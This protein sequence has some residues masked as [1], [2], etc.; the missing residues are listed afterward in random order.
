MNEIQSCGR[1][2]RQEKRVKKYSLEGFSRRINRFITFFIALYPVL[3]IS[4]IFSEVW[5]R[6]QFQH[7]TTFF[8]SSGT[9]L[10]FRIRTTWIPIGSSSRYVPTFSTLA[11]VFPGSTY[12]PE[13]SLANILIFIIPLFLLNIVL[14][15]IL[16]YFRKIF[17]DLINGVSPFT[18]KMVSRIDTIARVTTVYAVLTF[19]VP[20][21]FFAI[22]TWLMY[23]IFI[24]GKRLQDEYDTTL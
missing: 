3:L 14:F 12:V 9:I 18:D 6:F 5:H 1:S 16:V 24:H 2:K 17:I 21:V 23:Y 10:P 22:F 11:R 4:H 8:S 19:T 15:L 20:S 7:H 13:A